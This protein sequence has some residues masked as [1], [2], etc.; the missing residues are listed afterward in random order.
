MKVIYKLILARA[1][2]LLQASNL[3]LV[4]GCINF[5]ND[6]EGNVYKIPNYCINQPYFEKELEN[7]QNLDVVENKELKVLFFINF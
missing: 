3:K 5:F 4:N 2:K 6:N 1:R 7:V